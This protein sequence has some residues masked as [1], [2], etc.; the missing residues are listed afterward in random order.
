MLAHVSD[1]LMNIEFILS[2]MWP[3]SPQG[4]FSGEEAL[5]AAYFLLI[6]STTQLSIEMLREGK[7]WAQLVSSPWCKLPTSKNNKHISL[8][9]STPAVPL[10]TNRSSQQSC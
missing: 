10:H 5:R 1:C 2:S 6:Y 7:N 8:T 9:T 4:L 3:Q